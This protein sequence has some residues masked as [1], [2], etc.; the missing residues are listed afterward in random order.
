LGAER[1]DTD[2][3]RTLHREERRAVVRARPGVVR[4]RVA[5][6][7]D[8]EDA[9]RCLASGVLADVV[10]RELGGARRPGLLRKRG[11]LEELAVTLL[12]DLGAADAR[13]RVGRED[14]VAVDVPLDVVL[15]VRR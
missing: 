12:A 1:R 6:D 5:R 3:E 9:R 10:E 13:E 11:V 4:Q 15:Q 2:A 7:L 8:V 14:T